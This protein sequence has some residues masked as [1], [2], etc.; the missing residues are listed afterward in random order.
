MKKNL[1][2]VSIILL[3]VL[4]GVFAGFKKPHRVALVAHMGYWDCEAGGGECDVN[5]T[6]DN[7]VISCHGP[8]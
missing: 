5:Q 6:A 1:K 7:V 2:W 8:V 4:A 3:V